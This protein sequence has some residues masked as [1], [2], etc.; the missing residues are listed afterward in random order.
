V[1]PLLGAVPN[2][3]DEAGD[4]TRLIDDGHQFAGRPESLAALAHMPALVGRAALAARC[5]HFVF[6]ASARGV[7]RSEE[8]VDRLAEHFL[9]APSQ[10]AA[11]AFIPDGDVPF[12]IGAHNRIV[13][14]ALNDLPIVFG[15]C[16]LGPGLLGLHGIHTMAQGYLD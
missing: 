15:R 4:V 2:D 14:G 12:E 7:F 9:A 16:V 10:N 1:H 5:F 3:L 13:N 8:A 6:D 11:R